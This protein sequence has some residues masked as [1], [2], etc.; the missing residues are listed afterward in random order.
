M[1]NDY[2]EPSRDAVVVERRPL[3][4]PLPSSRRPE[5][6]GHTP[7]PVRAYQPTLPP[8]AD[9]YT[10]PPM[11]LLHPGETPRTRSRANDE[12]IAALRGVFDQFDVD[13]AVTGFARGPTVTR[14]EVELVAG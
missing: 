9:D 7:G 14:Y 11:S 5:A 6:P 4:V 1:P 10:L 2:D 12:V 8:P 13:A 3:S